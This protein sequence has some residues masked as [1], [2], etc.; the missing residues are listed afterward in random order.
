MEKGFFERK[1]DN[2]K[3][4]CIKKNLKDEKGIWYNGEAVWNYTKHIEK[5][6]PIEFELS[7]DGKALTFIKKSIQPSEPPKDYD[8][9]QWGTP[10]S[11]DTVIYD[12]LQDI[13][14]MV[15]SLIEDV[16]AIR[17]ELAKP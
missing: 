13:K 4:V 2:T 7:E 5:G 16:T 15:G 6:N 9:K 1:W 12:E 17:K 3:G 8:P 14:N 11:D 10:K